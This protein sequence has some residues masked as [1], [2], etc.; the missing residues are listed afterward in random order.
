MTVK[1]LKELLSHMPE[2][3][4]VMVKSHVAD[5]ASPIAKH[6]TGTIKSLDKQVGTFC[7]LP[8]MGGDEKKVIVLSADIN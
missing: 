8:V 1:Q 6:F 5:F 2:N 7:G 4:E 3:H